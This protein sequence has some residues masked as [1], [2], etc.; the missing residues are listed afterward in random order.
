[1]FEGLRENWRALRETW[2]AIDKQAAQAR[3]LRSL[4]P[5]P[6]PETI[7]KEARLLD[8]GGNV[9]GG[10]RISV[11]ER[12]WEP[13]YMEGGLVHVFKNA[14]SEKIEQHDLNP[15]RLAHFLIGNTADGKIIEDIARRVA[16]V[17]IPREES[18]DI[19]ITRAQM[20]AEALALIERYYRDSYELPAASAPG[21][22]DPALRAERFL[23]AAKGIFPAQAE[24]FH[25]RTQSR[26]QESPPSAMPS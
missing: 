10:S 8:S 19:T 22:P 24:V 7:Y 26:N 4:P 6:Q 18:E 9:I 12:Y 25:A 14:E 5:E 2:R 1:M 3:L 17:L 20:E 23:Q 13:T 16:T 11:A 15:K 21:Q